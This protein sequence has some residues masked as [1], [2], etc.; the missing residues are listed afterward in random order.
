MAAGAAQVTDKRP[1]RESH[2]AVVKEFDEVTLRR[3]VDAPGVQLPAG[4]RGV[5]VVVYMGRRAC[6]G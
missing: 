2:A 6:P 1:R 5:V 3:A 4:A